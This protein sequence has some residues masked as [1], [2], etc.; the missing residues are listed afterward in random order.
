MAFSL[1][2]RLMADT[3]GNVA[4]IFALA[5]LPVLAMIG[6]AI[7]YSRATNAQGEIRALVDSGAIAGA[8]NADRKAGPKNVEKMVR[9]RLAALF[10]GEDVSAEAAWIDE[11]KFAVTGSVAHKNTFGSLLQ[12]TTA[13]TVKAVASLGVEKRVIAIDP[14]FLGSEAG[15]FN[16]IY[17]YRL[18][19]KSG[20]PADLKRVFSNA[21][22][23]RTR[24]TYELAADEGWGFMLRN[25]RN[26]RAT[27]Q[28]E[29][30]NAAKDKGK[31]PAKDAKAEQEQTAR[32]QEKGSGVYHYYSHRKPANLREIGT[33]CASGKIRHNWED[34]P[35]KDSDFD[36]NDLMYEFD[37]T[38]RVVDTQRVHLS[39]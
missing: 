39:Q 7:D 17:I 34:R 12:D 11:H 26:A 30:E 19:R 13:L 8:Q 22:P 37:C 20:L 29:L 15:D 28:K 25:V 21:D 14:S 4:A 3:S 10:P 31:D 36:F 38:S 27:K 9:D 24:V 33:G 2:T 5:I 6:A 1:R 35:E 16:E 18:D 23:S 32:A